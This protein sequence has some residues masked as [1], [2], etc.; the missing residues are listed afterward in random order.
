MTNG[1]GKVSSMA[2]AKFAIGETEKHV[3]VIDNSLLWKHITIEI[4]GEKVVDEPHFSP[5]GKKFQFEVGSSEKHHVEISAG[6]F[7]HTELFVDGRAVH[8]S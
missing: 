8:E 3:I 4:D 7:S 6:G 5:Q 2:K 1:G